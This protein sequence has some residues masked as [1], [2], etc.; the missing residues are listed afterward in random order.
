MSEWA[1]P[2]G[3]SIKVPASSLAA[4]C[5][6][7]LQ[8]V[9]KQLSDLYTISEGEV[10]LIPVLKARLQREFPTG[11]TSGELRWPR[12]GGNGDASLTLAR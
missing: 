4:E 12:C 1:S 2:L 10:A 7:R 9:F 5:F 3:D 11:G 6:D 8:R